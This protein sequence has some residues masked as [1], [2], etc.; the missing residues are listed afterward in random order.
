MK[1]TLALLS[2]CITW[3]IVTFLTLAHQV[4]FGCFSF[5]LYAWYESFTLIKSS[6][7]IGSNFIYSQYSVFNT[8]AMFDLGDGDDIQSKLCLN[9][10]V[11]QV[12][13]PT[14]IFHCQ[15][16][17]CIPVDIKFYNDFFLFCRIF[18]QV[19]DIS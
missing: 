18:Y 11:A 10:S 4:S 9:R 3:T 17:D 1:C 8:E 15:M 2:V 7:L 5:S 6:I 13:W 16:C 14:Q 12:T 19:N